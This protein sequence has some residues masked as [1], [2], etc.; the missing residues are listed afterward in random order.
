M[1]LSVAVTHLYLAL[2]QV[3]EKSETYMEMVEEELK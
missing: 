1:K 3:K 2:S